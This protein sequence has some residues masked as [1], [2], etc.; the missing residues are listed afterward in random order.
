VIFSE[1][2]R[3]GFDLNFSLFGVPVR[4]HPL[5]WL[6][7]LLLGRP[8]TPQQA[9]VWIAAASLSIL[10]HEFGHVAAIAYYGARSHIV[11]HGFG[12]LAIQDTAWRRDPKSQII[13]SLAGP[14]AGFLLAGAILLGLQ[15]ANRLTEFSIGG[16]SI[17]VFDFDPSGMLYLD[18]LT[19]YLLFANIFWG[20]LNLLPVFPLDG[21]QATAALLQINDPRD[22]MRKALMLSIGVAALMLIYGFMNGWGITAFFFGFMAYQNYQLLQAYRGGYGGS[23]W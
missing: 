13:I 22:G 4:I 10:V 2:P 15:L 23:P 8:D 5:F 9:L 3:T 11:L 17:V 12:G 1:P 20:L 21:G 7:M 19:W 14:A 18:L 16:S 6:I